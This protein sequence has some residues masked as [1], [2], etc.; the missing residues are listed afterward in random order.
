MRPKQQQQ[1][2]GESEAKENRQIMIM[3]FGQRQPRCT[4]QARALFRRLLFPPIFVS[5]EEGKEREQ[6]VK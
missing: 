6:R 5:E 3:R 1:W 2:G 4:S